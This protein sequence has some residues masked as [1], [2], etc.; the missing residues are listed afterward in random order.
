MACFARVASA[1]AAYEIAPKYCTHLQQL[2]ARLHAEHARNFTIHC[3]DYRRHVGLDADFV[4][5][6]AEEP[7]LKNKNVLS[8]LKAQLQQGRLRATAEAIM[9][10]D[11]KWGP[12]R[13]DHQ[14]VMAG[15]YADK[16]T[17][18]EDVQVEETALCRNSTDARLR[19]KPY[20]CG[21]ARGI[22]HLAG[23]R[24]ASVKE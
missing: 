6:W 2:S 18:T 19:K 15:T 10:F 9:I 12:D 1:A 4:T 8:A 24:I 3:T 5:W 14:L 21:R 7:I 23:V 11:P 16:P 22:F 20:L 17:W 13:R